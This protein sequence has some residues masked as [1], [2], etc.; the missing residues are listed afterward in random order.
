[1]RRRLRSLADAYRAQGAA[2]LLACCCATGVAAERASATVTATPPPHAAVKPLTDKQVR[3][4][5]CE[6][7][8]QHLAET[9]R[10]AFI[11]ACLR[12]KSS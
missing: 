3:L 8:A 10:H 11:D 4:R 1:M 7:E 12:Q 5:H 2:L 9:A 6:N